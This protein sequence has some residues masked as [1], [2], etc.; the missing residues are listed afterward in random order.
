VPQGRGDL[1]TDTRDVSP[2]SRFTAKT[3]I[4]YG[5]PAKSLTEVAAVHRV[6]RPPRIGGWPAHKGNR[7]KASG[8]SNDQTLSVLVL[9]VLVLSVL[10]LFLSVALMCWTSGGPAKAS[11][12]HS[13]ISIDGFYCADG[14][15]RAH[16]A[17]C[18]GGSVNGAGHGAGQGPGQP[19]AALRQACGED[20]RRF[21]SAVIQDL[22]ARRACMKAHAADL[23]APC[24]AAI[25]RQFGSP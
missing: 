24:K 1:I 9:S 19:S 12:W 11:T 6:P 17:Q 14:S 7:I 16:L 3:T 22:Q 13:E 23:S 21:C 15:R 5:L 10:G 20:A 4:E 18:K 2:T 8:G 25:A